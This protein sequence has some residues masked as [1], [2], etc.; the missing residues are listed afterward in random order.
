MIVLI[1]IRATS[2]FSPINSVENRPV[3]SV[4]NKNMKLLLVLVVLVSMVVARPQLVSLLNI[5]YKNVKL[6]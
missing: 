6:I 3:L 2:P 4:Q 1:A 5:K